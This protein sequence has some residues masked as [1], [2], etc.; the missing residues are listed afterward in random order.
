M[1]SIVS[2]P[3]TI[4]IAKRNSC[5]KMACLLEGQMLQQA[6]LWNDRIMRA[7][8]PKLNHF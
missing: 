5:Q 7:A 4:V 2:L 3:N 1:E 6:W 8:T